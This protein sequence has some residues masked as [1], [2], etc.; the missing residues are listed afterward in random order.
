MEID[1]PDA[2]TRDAFFAAASDPALAAEI[3]EDEARLFDRSR[4][5]MFSV[6]ERGLGPDGRLNL[7]S[8]RREGRRTRTRHRP[9]ARPG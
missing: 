7:S 5:R 9:L 8:R 3:A 6:E 2:A 4:I 1:F